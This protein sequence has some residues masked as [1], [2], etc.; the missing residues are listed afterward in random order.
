MMKCIVA[1]L[2]FAIAASAKRQAVL[3]PPLAS[4]PPPPA[5]PGTTPSPSSQFNAPGVR[6]HCIL[7]D[8]VEFSKYDL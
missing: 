5:P 1:V 8:E 4:P 3:P 6:V 7:V 2:I